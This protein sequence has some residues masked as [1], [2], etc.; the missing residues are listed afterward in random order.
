MAADDSPQTRT[1]TMPAWKIEPPQPDPSHLRRIRLIE[2]IERML[3][4]RGSTADTCLVAAPPGY[5]KTTLL[6]HW[7]ESAAMPVVWYH[8]DAGDAD[9]ATFVYGLIR[10]LRTRLPRGHWQV[11][12]LLASLREGALSPVDIRRCAEVFIADLRGH[13]AKP[14]ALVI[15][16]V[17]TIAAASGSRELLER[18]LVRP[19][20][21]L[22]IVLECREI[23]GL[24]LSPLLPQRRL[25]GVGLEDLRFTQDELRDL[26]AIIGADADTTYIE[27]L[28]W[29][30]D[31]WVTG[32]L[33]ATGALWPAWLAPRAGDELNREAVFGYLAA[34]VLDKLPP[35]LLDFAMRSA[36][37]SYMTAPLCRG[38]L[39]ADDARE[40]LA[41]LERRTG[42]LSHVGRRP[43]EPVYRFQPVLREALLDQLASRLTE[44]ERRELH[45]RAAGL[46][47]AAGDDEEAAQHY[48]RAA[49]YDGLCHLIETRRSA[50]LRTGR[51]QTLARWIE[52]LP[53][54]LRADSPQLGISLVELHRVAGRT[55][56]ARAAVDE[57]VA[58]LLP[59]GA[60]APALT[61]RA[62]IVR[63]DVRYIQG[64]YSDAIRDCEAALAL[65]PEDADEL[66]VQAR[67]V[68][69]ACLK[70][71]DGPEAALAS[72]EGVEQRCQRLGDLWALA[73]LHYIRSSLALAQGAF[74]QA[75]ASAAAGLLYA[76][77]AGDE[78]RAI[79]CRLNLGAVHSH[80]GQIESSRRDLTAALE[81]ARAVGH[82]QGEAYALVNLGDLELTAGNYAAAL[83]MLRPAAELGQQIDDQQLRASMATVY[84]YA[85][86]LGGDP[87]AAL[88]WLSPV[89]AALPDERSGLDW[90]RASCTLG[91][92]RYR[93][94]DVAGA[95]E[96]LTRV[97]AYTDAHQDLADCAR[98]LLTLAAVRLAT[99]DVVQC[100]AALS[101][102]L[103]LARRID[104]TPSALMDV[105]H[106]PAL[107][108]VLEEMDDPLAAQLLS[109]VARPLAHETKPAFSIRN[110]AA[111]DSGQPDGHTDAAIRDDPIR[112]FA[113]G[114][115]RVLLGTERVTRWTRPR[116]RELLLFLLDQGGAV[117]G[118][119]IVEA[120]WNDRAEVAESE[121][122]KTRHALKQA[123]GR[124]CLAQEGGRWRL[125]VDCWVD[126]R[127]FERLSDEGARLFEQGDAREAA[128]I[129]RQALALWRG[130]YLDDCAGDWAFGRREALQRRYLDALEMLASIEM[131]QRH[132]DAAAQLCYQL[133]DADPTRESAHRGL[134]AYFAARGEFARALAQY[135]RCAGVLR[136]QMDLTPSPQ[137]DRLRASIRAKMREEHPAVAAMPF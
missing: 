32:A 83:D 97:I 28:Q 54:N 95:E 112:V 35:Q 50:L 119:V 93:L 43:Q 129:L 6:A 67:F 57:I 121:F 34:E 38:L 70:V 14:M 72:L 130:S 79:A 68:L 53:P 74:L 88:R 78:V 51:G 96:V 31:G 44:Q 23:P 24:R 39:G 76:Q 92:V 40:R 61:A 91:F 64:D 60:K 22:R 5:G 46:L 84:P 69:A 56:E 10:A 3:G 59:T 48:A 126:A 15:T 71:S 107:W 109:A 30:C 58:R 27:H 136:E 63:A 124:D 128:V 98:A 132:F 42:F 12:D 111:A 106:L 134:M 19:P 41:A 108:P 73:R 133:L 21:G 105:R 101:D 135:T 26:L 122:R 125:T 120:I 80:L 117:R 116:T 65:A 1:R 90:A 49:D 18:V 113:L 4:G 131:Q 110:R 33:L 115:T 104:G 66:I 16:G 25:E 55:A 9:P 100:H 114:E 127:E 123:L 45:A 20:D 82:V 85:L 52:L 99:A 11:K 81:Q 7:A 47:E 137:T 17:D 77:E 94:G 75:E 2:R 118:D 89:I 8:A 103:R 37:L 86:T 87:E 13:I 102:A 36:L 29:L 62:L